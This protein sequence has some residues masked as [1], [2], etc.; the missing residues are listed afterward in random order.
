MSRQR[1]PRA[2]SIFLLELIIAIFIFIVSAAV[3][4]EILA[5]ARTYSREAA[6]LDIAVSEC[7]S[8]AET[9]YSSN[10]LSDAINSLTDLYPEAAVKGNTV[11]ITAGSMTIQCRFRTMEGMLSC[12]IEAVSEGKTIY[13]L[14]AEHFPGKGA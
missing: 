1:Q 13:S 9:V 14:K 10:G 7:S 6:T 3:C 11:T 2:S 5:T 12:R 4:V 8:V